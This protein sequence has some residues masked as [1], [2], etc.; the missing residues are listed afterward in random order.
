M[1][2]E[3]MRIRTASSTERTNREKKQSRGLK[4]V[5]TILS[6]LAL[7]SIAQ[8]PALTQVPSEKPDSPQIEKVG[9]LEA[10]AGE[11]IVRFARQ[12]FSTNLDRA[13]LVADATEHRQIGSTELSLYRLKSGSRKVSELVSMMSSLPGVVYAEPNYIVRTTLTP[14]DTR[15]GELWGL[16]NTGQSGGV[17]GADISAV[18]AW[19]VSTGSSSVVV[20]VIDSGVDFNHPDLAA[21]MWSAPTSFTV[22]I[23]GQTITCPQGSRGFNAINNTCVP[24]DD[25]NHGTHCAGTIG[26]VGNNAQGVVGVNWTTRIMGLKFLSAAGSGSTADAID[27]I[28]FAIQAKQAFAG[29]GGANVRV[30]SN[31]WGG[32]GFSQALLDQINKANAN[33]MLFVAAAGNN[34][35]NNDVTPHFPSNY[36]A[37]NV[38]SVASTTRT[39]ARSSFSNFGATSVDLGA[40]GSSI[41]STVRNGGFAVFSGTSMATPH[42]SGAAALVLSECTLN[43]AALKANLMNNVDLIS[44]MSGITVTGGRL[45]VDKAI[46]ACAG[47]GGPGEPVTIFFDNF[48]TSQGWT[49]NPNGTDTATTGQ[50][51]RANPETTTSSGTK[52]LG[53]TV[54]G[55]NDLVTGAPAGTSAGANDIDGG[56][57]SIQS[58]LITLSGGTSFT[59]S[60]SFYLAHGTNSSSADFF[61]VR[62]VAGSTVTTVFQEL[63]AANDDDAFWMT[64]TID[65]SQFAGQTIRILIEAADASGASLVEAAVDDVRIVRN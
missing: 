62:I 65:L 31:S 20:G 5:L 18:S 12:G 42:V 32:G 61:R 30:L 44:S 54:S 51:V 57:T 45:N 47:G 38:V 4:Y 37:A 14:N 7:F 19:D 33:D 64:G 58:P 53:T 17:A 39:D 34:G 10:V 29:S 52:Q 56:T 27:C 25:N 48:E 13:R 41:L 43:T 15:F 49:T 16:N 36:A 26:A 9:E 1:E 6:L 22:T 23:G 2:E 46:R 24:L 8:Q 60:F 55:A 28:E 35:S 11:V 40:P 59:L 63:G 50:W 21:N 3:S